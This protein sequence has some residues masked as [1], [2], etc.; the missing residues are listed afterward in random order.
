MADARQQ[1]EKLRQVKIDGAPGI[2][3][4]LPGPTS[5]YLKS[6][7]LPVILI[8]ISAI[9]LGW[10]VVGQQ[11]GGG[12]TAGTPVRP[13]TI[14]GVATDWLETRIDNLDQKLAFISGQISDL[15]A[16]QVTSDK[17][18]A[19]I[20]RLNESVERL[21]RLTAGLGAGGVNTV[22]SAARG[23]EAIANTAGA[24]PEAIAGARQAPPES[25]T[26]APKAVS[27]EESK[28]SV[29]ELYEKDSTD[30]TSAVASDPEPARG[31]AW[32]INLISSPKKED[33]VNFANR[34]KSRGIST[35]LRQVS[36]RG[37]PYWRVL[38]SGFA[39]YDEAVAHSDSVKQALGLRDTWIYSE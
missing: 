32:N 28:R 25:A 19:Q 11:G 14:D 7:Y 5:S 9:L 17:L 29:Q 20:A 6:S 15:E 13:D 8:L 2:K 35:E 31:G 39:T 12:D 21:N 4:A 37:T 18:E 27:S 38:I 22:T 24:G 23:Q 1:R 16:R 33:A 34:A 30:A 36:V 3:P 26:N 10:A